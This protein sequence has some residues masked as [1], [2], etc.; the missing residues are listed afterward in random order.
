MEY[1][2]ARVYIVKINLNI[3]LPV[4]SRL[5][6]N[7]YDDDSIYTVILHKDFM[8]VYNNNGQQP[9]IIKLKEICTEIVKNTIKAKLSVIHNINI[10][11]ND[12]MIYSMFANFEFS[13][14]NFMVL[15]LK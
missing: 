1:H 7:Y 13:P 5:Q 3:L 4:L 12:R 6:F 11:D 14:D 15:V 8:D 2:V 9:N 10:T